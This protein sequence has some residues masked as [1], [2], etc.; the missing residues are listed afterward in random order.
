MTNQELKTL[1]DTELLEII[2]VAD[3][4]DPN[5]KQISQLAKVDGEF[6]ARMYHLKAKNKSDSIK[7]RQELIKASYTYTPTRE[8]SQ[9]KEL[10]PDCIYYR[11]LN[12]TGTSVIVECFNHWASPTGSSGGVNS[13]ILEIQ[14]VDIRDNKINQLISE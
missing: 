14:K 2:D 5:F 6:R 1:S 11:V 3:V 9:M 4:N 10:I 13:Q 12:E 7:A 8:L